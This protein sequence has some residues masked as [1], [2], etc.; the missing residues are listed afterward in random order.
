MS[1]RSMY[2]G[3]PGPLLA[4]SPPA[5][6]AADSPAEAASPARPA[7]TLAQHALD[8][9]AAAL[10]LL[11]P[12]ARWS[13]NLC[14]FFRVDDADRFLLNLRVAALFHDIGKANQDFQRAVTTDRGLLQSLRHEHLSAL[15][16][17]LPP[18]RA[19]L[20]G[21]PVL[22]ADA[23]TAAV[24]SHHL[25]ATD[26][27]GS[28][29]TWCDPRTPRATVPVYLD[30]ADVAAILDRVR[31]AAALPAP[32][33]LPT[34]AWSPAP[35]WEPAWRDG[36]YRAARFRRALR[37]DPARLALT[38][39]LKAAVIAADSVASAMV[40]TDQSISAWIDQVAHAPRLTGD[41]LQRAIIGPRCHSLARK[42]GKPFALHAFQDRAATLGPRALLVAGCGSGKT[43]AAWRW[44]Q[45]QLDAHA[46]GHVIFLYPTRGTATEGFRDYVAWAPEDEAALV[47]GTAGYELEAMAQN[48]GEAM[49]GKRLVP[50]EAERRLFA[51]GLW[52]RRYFS[53]TV[54]QLLSFLE[55]RYDSM[56][57]LPLLADSAVILDEVHSYDQRMFERLMDFLRRFDL[58]VLCMTA[59]LPP[60]RRRQL[61]DAGLRV[62]P[63]RIDHGPAHDRAD[64][65]D[66]ADLADLAQRESHP[67]Y[68]IELVDGLDAALEHAV[69]AHRA[70][71]RVLWV[72]NTVRRCQL[73]SRRLAGRLGIRPLT[74]H[75][76][77]RLSDR[78]QRHAATVRAFQ[79]TGHGDHGHGDHGHGAQSGDRPRNTPAIAVTTQVCEM[80]L[81]LDADVLISELA[82]ASALVQRMGRANRHLA[83]GPDFRAAVYL[84]APPDHAPYAKDDLAAA[85]A[86]LDELRSAGV[87][88]QASQQH[89]AAALERHA[90]PEPRVPIDSAGFLTGGYFAVPGD[91]RDSDD[92]AATCVLDSDLPALEAL[93]ADR[94]WRERDLPGY[95]LSVPRRRLV[96]LPGGSNDRPPWLPA[97]VHIAPG[98]EYDPELGFLAGDSV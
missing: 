62:Y 87:L 47:H 63:P 33:P 24:L 75:S 53:A 74:Y 72:V 36:L 54:D 78:Q 97:Y 68:C 65:A 35:P 93:R 89:L 60:A 82:P 71:L 26:R 8:T 43:L 86:L 98:S 29:F 85:R 14:R 58:P 64:S 50:D 79:D 5:G 30:H 20:A 83:R 13:R 23:I 52:R 69:G 70:G 9:E 2:P 45:A 6:A 56:C 46:L 91:F 16:L 41:D 15:I 34:S 92:H 1:A 49:D 37:S 73:V 55:H 94:H 17:C 4:K 76:R 3:T 66:L 19:W 22:D 51:L 38:L 12:G 77:F 88:H 48:P 42:L 21:N 59:T 10:C 96:D 39:A 61:E 28:P 84:Y 27:T 25:K 57:L 81:D 90:T 95:L 32:P 40:R 7:L 67:R 11:H 31:H 44:A 18:V 80:S